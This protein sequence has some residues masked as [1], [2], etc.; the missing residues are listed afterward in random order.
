MSCVL[1]N[2]ISL[3]NCVP[4]TIVIL[5]KK[6]RMPTGNDTA[7]AISKV[8]KNL[9]KFKNYRATGP[10]FAGQRCFNYGTESRLIYIHQITKLHPLS[11]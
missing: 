11:C 5:Y 2:M 10:R 3:E 6:M 9:Y 1:I 4:V 8:L 7:M